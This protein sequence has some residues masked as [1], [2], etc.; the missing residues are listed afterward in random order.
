VTVRTRDGTNTYEVGQTALIAEVPE[1]EPLVRGWRDRFDAAA[2]AGVPAHVTVLVPFLNRRL[3]SPGI[4]AELRQIFARHPAFSVQ[5]AECRRFPDVLYL[6]PVPDTRFRALTN[7]VATRWPDVPPYG[8]QFE[9]VVPHLTVAHG[10][11]PSLL[12]KIEADLSPRLPIRAHISAVQLLAF[13]GEQWID[14]ELF[15]LSRFDGPPPA[16]AG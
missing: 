13:T 9:D 7:A 1:A 11:E 8:G 10:Q 4:R 5:F 2:A 14:E 16:P 12:D 6:A 3:L 15:E